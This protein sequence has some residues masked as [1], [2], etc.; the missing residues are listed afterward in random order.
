VRP[1]LIHIPG[2]KFPVAV[3]DVGLMHH[4]AL[5]QCEADIA[6]LHI[7]PSIFYRVF[8]DLHQNALKTLFS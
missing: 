3:C 6:L 1:F 5:T 7:M 2:N 8:S 4:T